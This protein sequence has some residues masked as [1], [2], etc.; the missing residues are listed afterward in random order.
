[1]ANQSN[2]PVIWTRST[3][4]LPWNCY[5]PILCL[6]TWPLFGLQYS[7]TQLVQ[8][9]YCDL[10]T[11]LDIFRFNIICI[12]WLSFRKLWKSFTVLK[13]LKTAGSDEFPARLIK[14]RI[15]TNCRPTLLENLFLQVYKVAYFQIVENLPEWHLFTNLEKN[16]ISRITGQSL[17]LLY[18][19]L[20]KCRILMYADDTVILYSDKSVK[21]V[22]VGQQFDN[23][24]KERQIWIRHVWSK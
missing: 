16:Q 15:R 7:I 14:G 1:M 23:E 19:A 4:R 6:L 11:I 20:N 24:S 13:T 5:Q 12:R 3:V 2:R 10:S 21:A 17:Y 22:L 8:H 9:F 18:L